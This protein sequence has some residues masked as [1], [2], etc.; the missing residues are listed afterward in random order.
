MRLPNQIKAIIK[1]N[2]NVKTIRVS[3]VAILHLTILDVS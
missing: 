2:E 1:N 3:T